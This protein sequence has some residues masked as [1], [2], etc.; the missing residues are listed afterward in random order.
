MQVD[1]LSFSIDLSQSMEFV[2][3][4]L[5]SLVRVQEDLPRVRAGERV[6]DVSSKFVRLSLFV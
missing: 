3:R 4:Y 1:E 6:E 2:K 5:G